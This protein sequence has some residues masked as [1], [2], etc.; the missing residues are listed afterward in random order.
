MQTALCR[1][2]LKGPNGKLRDSRNIY[3]VNRLALE[4]ERMGFGMGVIP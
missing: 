1:T 3:V 4:I 2:G